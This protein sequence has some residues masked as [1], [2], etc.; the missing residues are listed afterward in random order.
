[1]DFWALHP[2]EGTFAAIFHCYCC[3]KFEF[4]DSK[5]SRDQDFHIFS[6]IALSQIAIAAAQFRR[7]S[8]EIE[9]LPTLS[10]R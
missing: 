2:S 4:Q 10:L 1:M 3:H 6:S 7:F 9:G 5:K 8:M